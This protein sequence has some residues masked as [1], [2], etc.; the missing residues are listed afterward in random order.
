MS[1][2]KPHIS[3]KLF[4]KNTKQEYSLSISIKKTLA[5]FHKTNII[6]NYFYLIYFSQQRL[7]FWQMQAFFFTAKKLSIPL[8]SFFSLS[9]HYLKIYPVFISKYTSLSLIDKSNYF[10]FKSSSLSIKSSF[11]FF[12]SFLS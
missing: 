7:R 9:I 10:F 11:F 5:L 12:F 3:L 1:Y 2:K 8:H 4:H 6:L